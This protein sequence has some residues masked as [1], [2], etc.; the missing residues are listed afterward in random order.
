[1]PHVRTL[2]EA[3]RHIQ[4]ADPETALT[5]HALR[6]L[7]LSGEFP[8]IKIGTKKLVDVDLLEKFL[9]GEYTPSQIK[10]NPCGEIRPLPERLNKCS[11]AYGEGYEGGKS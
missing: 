1:M 4:A 5:H 10:T 3:V 2:P 8:H 6:L 9:S 7:V 11:K